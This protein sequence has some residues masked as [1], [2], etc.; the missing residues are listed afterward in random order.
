MSLIRPFC[1][2]EQVTTS[3]AFE[4]RRKDWR[5]PS[6]CTYFPE[7]VAMLLAIFWLSDPSEPWSE[8]TWGTSSNCHSNVKMSPIPVN[9]NFMHFKGKAI[10]GQ[11][12]H[13]LRF[14]FYIALHQEEIQGKSKLRILTH[15]AVDSHSSRLF[16]STSLKA[17]LTR[18]SPPM[19]VFKLT[20][21]DDRLGQ[22]LFNLFIICVHPLLS[23]EDGA[24]MSLGW[25]PGQKERIGSVSWCWCNLDCRSH[26]SE[27]KIKMQFS[28]FKGSTALILLNWLFNVIIIMLYMRIACFVPIIA[29]I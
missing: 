29:F 26:S 9:L 12:L 24:E 15:H 11:W 19:L 25:E 10:L 6:S 16:T 5:A 1:R 7:S 3:R 14:S 4:I 2:L 8:Y 22:T 27:I 20:W 18:A 23:W 28:Y 17:G 13:S 21:I